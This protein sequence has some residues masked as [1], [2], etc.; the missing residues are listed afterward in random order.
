MSLA[1]I[2]SIIAL[3][4]LILSRMLLFVILSAVQSQAL[5]QFLHPLWLL[6]SLCIIHLTSFYVCHCL[7]HKHRV[8]V[9]WFCCWSYIYIF[10]FWLIELER[11]IVLPLSRQQRVKAWISPLAPPGAKSSQQRRHAPL[12]SADHR[13]GD[14]KRR[15]DREQGWLREGVHI[16]TCCRILFKSTN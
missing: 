13:W 16:N 9:S 11:L 10:F 7:R 4:L 14:R 1:Q 6:T 12:C 15:F 3:V 5:C 2:V 8:N